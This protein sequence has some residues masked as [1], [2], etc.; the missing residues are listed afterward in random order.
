VKEDAAV[1]RIY[2]PQEDLDKFG[3]TAEE[4]R[5]RPDLDRV[6]PLLAMEADRAREFYRSGEELIPLV[7]EDSQP[8][9]WVLV[10]IYRALLEKI[11]AKRY[12][13][14]SERVSL[15]FGEKFKIL[16]R[17]FVQRFT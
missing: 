12:D 17:G 1:D 10:T 16:V 4:I 7:D 14:F 2:L 13:V 8:G 6:R 9:L 11:A 3:V 15:T 5:R